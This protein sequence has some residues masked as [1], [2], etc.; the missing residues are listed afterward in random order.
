MNPVKDVWKST[1]TVSGELS[2]MTG[3]A[4]STQE[5]H[6]TVSASGEIFHYPRSQLSKADI[7]SEVKAHEGVE[8]CIVVIII[9]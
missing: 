4:M 6:A 3:S 1:T 2:A 7:A 8:T 5:S 9:F